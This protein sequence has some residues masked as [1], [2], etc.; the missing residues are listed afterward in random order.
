MVCIY[1]RS[2]ILA[3][4]RLSHASP[5]NCVGAA[6]VGRKPRTGY[7]LGTSGCPYTSSSHYWLGLRSNNRHLPP[8]KPSTSKLSPTNEPSKKAKKCSHHDPQRF[9]LSCERIAAVVQRQTV[10]RS[11]EHPPKLVP[12]S[13]RHS[14]TRTKRNYVKHNPHPPLQGQNC[15]TAGGYRNQ[16]EP[17]SNEIDVKKYDC[18]CLRPPVDVFHS[19]G[20]KQRFPTEGHVLYVWLETKIANKIA[21]Y[22][23]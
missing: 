12:W 23:K 2:A 1:R 11:L 18:V 21:M 13:T 14:P 19:I 10:A 9:S 17:L 4:I 16:K 6:S 22:E 7:H 15:R 5:H 3:T 20:W 8:Q